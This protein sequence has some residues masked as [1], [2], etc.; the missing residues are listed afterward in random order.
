MKRPGASANAPATATPIIVPI[1][2]LACDLTRPS[3]MEKIAAAI[4]TRVHTDSP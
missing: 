1:I 3:R 2:H 4:A